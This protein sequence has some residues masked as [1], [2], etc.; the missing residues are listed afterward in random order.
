MAILSPS[1]CHAWG[2]QR[3]PAS[4]KC[5]NTSFLLLFLEGGLGGGG[6]WRGGEAC[7]GGLRLEWLDGGVGLASGQQPQEMLVFLFKICINIVRHFPKLW[8]C[9][10]LFEGS[11]Q[12]MFKLTSW[13]NIVMFNK[14]FWQYIEHSSVGPVVQM[15]A[16]RRKGSLLVQP[17]SWEPMSIV[18]LE[19]SS[20][21]PIS[22][23]LGSRWYRQS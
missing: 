11:P 4:A 23:I 13:P 19:L 10:L 15:S 5:Y 21:Q 9:N 6:G 1:S 3:S 8:Y 17:T 16:L 22:N 14:P 12:L 18:K 20:W 2:I 7:N